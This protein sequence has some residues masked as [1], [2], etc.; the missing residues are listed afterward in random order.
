MPENPGKDLALSEPFMQ[1]GQ[2]LATIGQQVQ[3]G[4][5]PQKVL[6]AFDYV[7]S[8]LQS[9]GKQVEDAYQ[10]LK[11]HAETLSQAIA[12]KLQAQGAEKPPDVPASQPSMS[13]KPPDLDEQGQPVAEG[14]GPMNFAIVNGQRVPIDQAPDWRQAVGKGQ[15]IFSNKVLAGAKENLPA[16]GGTVG[17]IAAGPAG[18]FAGGMTG[19]RLKQYANA[20]TG[21][22]PLPGQLDASGRMLKEGAVQGG[23]ALGSDLIGKG[24]QQGGEALYRSV[25]KPSLA[26]ANIGNADE[27][28]ARAINE[29]FPITR[30]GEGRANALIGQLK[31]QVTKI[32]AA[33][34]DQTDL[35]AV[36]DELRQ[37][38]TGKFYK[39]GV[40]SA[41]FDAAMK[42]A[43]NIDHHASLAQTVM[44]P[45]TRTVDTGIV[46]ESGQPMTRTV[47]EQ[48]PTT[49]YRRTVTQPEAQAVKSSLQNTGADASLLD[50]AATKQANEAGGHFMRVA[51]EKATPAIAPLNARESQL[52]DTAQAI[53]RAVQREANQYKTIQ[54][55]RGAIGAV[56]GG[57]EYQRSHDPWSAAAI[58]LGTMLALQP[59]T[60]S[61]VAIIASRL[62]RLSSIAPASAA[63]I[64]YAAV[65]ANK[66][67]SEEQK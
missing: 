58:G 11:K 20:A 61:R 37:W 41:D 3:S 43:D 18:A 2:V 17:Q 6:D 27:I 57:G 14:G 40:P 34:P 36:A 4:D 16:I 5:V 65:Q 67:S 25:L 1:F 9:G 39:P 19:E 32:Q 33:S 29:G 54:G 12:P 63:R 8:H 23:I 48:K 26:A 45:V 42:V 56:L 55:T 31:N 46:N 62:G 15:V 13:G 51:M 52:I 22:E 24:L 30:G 44:K 64:A 66:D 38:A 50:S 59:G 49:V 35:H 60:V 28:V 53:N 47:V 7:K 10:T 21:T